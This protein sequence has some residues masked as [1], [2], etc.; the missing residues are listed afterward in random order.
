VL[1]AASD[2][3]GRN[4]SELKALLAISLR[5]RLKEIE[6]SFHDRI[7]AEISKM[8]DDFAKKREGMEGKGSSRR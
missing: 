5:D 6:N 8:T 1:S 3:L 2:L 7:S 4:S